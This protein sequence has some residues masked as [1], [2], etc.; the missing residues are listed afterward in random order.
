LAFQITLSTEYE[1]NQKRRRGANDLLIHLVLYVLNLEM[2]KMSN[3]IKFIIDRDFSGKTID[4]YEFNNS[5]RYFVEMA[6]RLYHDILMKDV[7]ELV[8]AI[9]RGKTQMEVGNIFGVSAGSINNFLKGK[10]WK[11]I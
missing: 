2:E 8:K 7:D 5:D 1:R 10:T 4:G 3:K 11:H 6:M 9:E